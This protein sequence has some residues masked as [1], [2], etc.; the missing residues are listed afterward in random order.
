M[1]HQ[2]ADCVEYA[3]RHKGADHLKLATLNQP[4]F[5]AES[6]DI[7]AFFAAVLV[8]L[9][10]IIYRMLSCCRNLRNRKDVQKTAEVNKKTK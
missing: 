10:F 6:Y 1:S 4:Y 9:Y 3:I 2:V 7:V 8:C 5:I